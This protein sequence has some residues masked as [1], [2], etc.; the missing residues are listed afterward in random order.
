MFSVATLTG[1]A[2]QSWGPYTAL[3][4]N[5]PAKNIQLS[6]DLQSKGETWGDPFE[7]SSYRKEDV[8]TGDGLSYD[9]VQ[10]MSGKPRGHQFAAGFL[11][12]ASGISK[13]GRDSEAPIP[14]VHIDV[15]P[16]AVESSDFANG[17][18]TGCTIAGLTAKF[19]L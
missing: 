4:E 14:Y 17:K 10:H 19:L 18:P 1:H 11:M 16:S 5:G 3:V 2:V 8:L 13:H 7:V 6:A 15:A 9:V 12:I